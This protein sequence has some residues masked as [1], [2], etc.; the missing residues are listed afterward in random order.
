MYAAGNTTGTTKVTYGT[1]TFI[2]Q[3]LGPDFRI[4][5]SFFTT[6]VPNSPRP[7]YALEAKIDCCGNK[8]DSL[9]EKGKD[10]NPAIY[11][12]A[13]QV[14]EY[15]KM[16]P[17]KPKELIVDGGVTQAKDLVR[18]QSEISGIPVL[19]QTVFDGTALG[20]AKLVQS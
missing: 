12:L 9:L 1:G 5:K 16:L 19:K 7:S 18:I 3:I 11:D 10:L 20:V 14:N 2:V 13:T 17:K 4:K 6:L 15:I 8:I